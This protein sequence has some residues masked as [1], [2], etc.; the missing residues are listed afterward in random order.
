MPLPTYDK[1]KRKKSFQQLPKGAYVIKIKDAKEEKWPSGDD[2][3]RIAFDIA[4]GE[5]T[6]F[7]QKQF[8]S[9]TNEDKRWPMDAV[10]NLNVPG[11]GSEQYVWDNWNTFFADLEDSNGGFVF[12]GDLKAMRGKVVGGLFHVKQSEGKDRE[13][14]KV[15]YDHTQMKWTRPAADIR[16][17]KYGRLP[18]DKLIAASSAE[19]PSVNSDDGFM[20][21]P[22]GSEGEL[23]F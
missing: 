22:E 8:E 15:I 1:S 20:K 3:V 21:I 17:G 16:S 12:S 14:N 9:N 19:K 2:V 6:G 23:P 5:Y 13:G 7:Y 18:N 10:F 11:D 4:E